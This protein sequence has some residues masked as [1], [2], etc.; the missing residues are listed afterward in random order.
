MG[1]TTRSAIVAFERLAQAGRQLVEVFAAVEARLE[2]A[3][4]PAMEA[5]AKI[6]AGRQQPDQGQKAS[7]PPTQQPFAHA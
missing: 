7:N 4:R 6:G 1:L 5:F 2:Q 3:L